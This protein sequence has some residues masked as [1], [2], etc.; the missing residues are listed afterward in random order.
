MFE[1]DDKTGFN[2]S[3]IN[4]LLLMKLNVCLLITNLDLLF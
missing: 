3:E 2:L 1:D 4:I